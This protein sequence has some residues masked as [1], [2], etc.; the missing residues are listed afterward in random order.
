MLMV[1]ILGRAK[2]NRLTDSHWNGELI[3]NI[4]LNARNIPAKRRVLRTASVRDDDDE[5]I[6]LWVRWYW[7][8]PV[9]SSISINIINLFALFV[10]LLRISFPSQL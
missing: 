7:W 1:I 6:A 9:E 5:E 10:L 3:K 8:V 2:T 4:S